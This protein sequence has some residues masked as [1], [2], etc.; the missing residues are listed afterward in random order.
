MR[1]LAQTD[2]PEI[3]DGTVSISDFLQ[4]RIHKAFTTVADDLCSMGFLSTETRIDVSGAI[5]DV[6]ELFRE[7]MAELGID[8][9]ELDNRFARDL[10]MKYASAADMVGDTLDTITVVIVDGE[11]VRNE[12]DIYFTAGGH[13]WQYDFIPENEIW[14]DDLMPEP[15]D[16]IASLV[17]ELIERALMKHL[18]YYNDPAHELASVGAEAL[19]TDWAEHE[20]PDGSNGFHHNKVEDDDWDMTDEQVKRAAFVGNEVVPALRDAAENAANNGEWVHDKTSALEALRLFG[21]DESV[22]RYVAE[23]EAEHVQGW[24]DVYVRSA[25]QLPGTYAPLAEEEIEGTGKIGAEDEENEVDEKESGKSYDPLRS[26]VEAKT[27]TRPKTG[28]WYYYNYEFHTKFGDPAKLPSHAE[29]MDS[30]GVKVVG[31]DFDRI[32]RGSV[33]F[34]G[35]YTAEGRLGGQR[36]RPIFIQRYVRPDRRGVRLAGSANHR[37]ELSRGVW[38]VGDDDGGGNTIGCPIHGGRS[39]RPAVGDAS[40]GA[41]QIFIGGH[42]GR[43][44]PEPTG[45]PR[46]LCFAKRVRPIVLRIGRRAVAKAGGLIWT[47]RRR[48][49]IG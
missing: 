45:R 17:H 10:I 35:A 7:K 33:Y 37:G 30:E 19:R 42:A 39:L 18:N 34:F 6:L 13:H 48:A 11:R 31:V 26:I 1:R 24:L 44:P 36:P 32:P 12:L 28:I 23:T 3:R 27:K 16:M 20:T 14:I 29:W 43:Y 46:E 40:A 8:E 21:S 4:S 2:E 49:G 47:R 15:L 25:Q 41:E 22:I 5:G 38:A 9:M